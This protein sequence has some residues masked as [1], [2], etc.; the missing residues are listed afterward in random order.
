MSEPSVFEGRLRAAL[1]HRV[2]DGPTEFDA[3]GFARSVAAAEPRR[4]GLARGLLGRRRAPDAVPWGRSAVPSLA[5]L[6]V[7]LL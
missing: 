1:R 4:R 7:A 2:A 6:L 5:W 3:V